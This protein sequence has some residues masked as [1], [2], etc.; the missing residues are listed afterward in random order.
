MHIVDL[1][2]SMLGA[3]GIQAERQSHDRRGRTAVPSFAEPV[4]LSSSMH[5]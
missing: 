2:I 5:D 1:G 3:N 4:K